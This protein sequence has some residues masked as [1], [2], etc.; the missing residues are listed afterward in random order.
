MDTNHGV[1]KLGE[2]SVQANKDNLELLAE[3]LRETSRVY[4]EYIEVN[5]KEV[6]M[7]FSSGFKLIIKSIRRNG[8]NSFELLLC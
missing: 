8:K 3:N 2:K 7:K 1:V 4:T 5:D 6:T